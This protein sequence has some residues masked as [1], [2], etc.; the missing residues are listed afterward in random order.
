MRSA[1]DKIRQITAWC[2]SH[3]RFIWIKFV[4]W[5][6]ESNEKETCQTISKTDNLFIVE[7]I[8]R[9]VYVPAA[10]LSCFLFLSFLFIWSLRIYF[11][12]GINSISN[13]KYVARYTKTLDIV[14]V[15]AIWI[16]SCRFLAATGVKHIHSLNS[17]QR[18]V[19]RSTVVNTKTSVMLLKMFPRANHCLL[20]NNNNA[21]A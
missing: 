20:N 7:Y 9:C 15:I 3:T 5:S 21:V 17:Y 1:R 11:V 2:Q 18:R 6:I 16:A 10:A 19:A 4:A 12:W 13:G 8:R 14:F